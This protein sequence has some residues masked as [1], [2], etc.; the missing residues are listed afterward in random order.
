MGDG[1]RVDFTNLSIPDRLKIV[2]GDFLQMQED[3]FKENK[4]VT[5]IL[6]PS[7][8]NR[9]AGIEI[10]LVFEQ[11]LEFLTSTPDVREWVRIL[12][13]DYGF[14]ELKAKKEV[15]N[16][17][18][19]MLE[20]TGDLFKCYKGES[21]VYAP[22]SGCFEHYGFDFMIGKNSNPN[23]EFEYKTYLLEVNPGPDFKQSGRKG[24]GVVRGMLE[25]SVDLCL[26]GGE[27]REDEGWRFEKVY[28]KEEG[29][30]K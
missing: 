7:S 3:F 18:K 19:E 22:L 28:E 24:E 6:K 11:L 2:C 30:G 12:I 17:M 14:N 13:S 25:E 9:G 15:E 5:W 27:W 4:E 8:I 29:R 10:F 20:L 16:I 1:T 26:G 23:S 21:N